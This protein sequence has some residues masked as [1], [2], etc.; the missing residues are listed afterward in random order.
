MTAACLA[1]G[2]RAPSSL[3]R[4]RDTYS[5]YN[6]PYSI[7]RWLEEAKPVADVIL[8]TDADMLL[9]APMD[10]GELGVAPGKPVAA[11]YG[12]LKGVANAMADAIVPEVRVKASASVALLGGVAMTAVCATRGTPRP[13]LPKLEDTKG[14]VVGRRAD[15]AS[16]AWG[17][18]PWVVTVAA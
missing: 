8:I 17:G 3:R 4:R 7:A 5:A 15:Q 10:P 13:Q 2:P 16:L 6:K 14:G 9:R 1:A 12:Y 18:G 11:Y